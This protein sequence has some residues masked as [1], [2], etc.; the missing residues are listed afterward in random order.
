MD[1]AKALRLAGEDPDYHVRDMYE[2]IERGEYPTWTIAV[3]VMDPSELDK[4]NLEVFDPTYTW[5]HKDYPLR[6][7][8]K[9]TLNKNVSVSSSVRIMPQILGILTKASRTTTSK[10][11]NKQ[12]FRH[13]TWFLA[14]VLQQI[15]VS[16]LQLAI[17]Y[18]ID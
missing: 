5:P 6:P 3:Q 4:T 15:S 12:L 13:R 2:A 8:G 11:L 7:V 9:L 17:D 10:T 16:R 14:L 18:E 1:P